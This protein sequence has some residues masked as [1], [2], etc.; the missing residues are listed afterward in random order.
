[1]H[2]SYW[3]VFCGN[4]CR[5]QLRGQAREQTT[6]GS[7]LIWP[8]WQRKQLELTWHLAPTPPSP[9]LPW[10]WAPLGHVKGRLYSPRLWSLHHRGFSLQ[11]YHK[12][13]Y[14]VLP[15][16][17]GV[18]TGSLALED[19]KR[20]ICFLSQPVGWRWGAE[21]AG[22]CFGTPFCSDRKVRASVPSVRMT[23]FTASG[24]T[25]PKLRRFL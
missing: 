5:W 9:T 12:I 19:E 14:F 18:F 23:W 11:K 15:P 22:S 20:H 1:M 13:C 4:H 16:C 24:L 21:G 3:I 2:F 10:P 25:L 6:S 7:L 17:R 8:P